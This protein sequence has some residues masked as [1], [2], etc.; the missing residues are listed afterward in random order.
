MNPFDM[1]AQQQIF[2]L[3][4]SQYADIARDTHK[5]YIEVC[6]ALA[7]EQAKV[8]KLEQEL[9]RVRGVVVQSV[10]KEI[11]TVSQYRVWVMNTPAQTAAEVNGIKGD[12]IEYYLGGSTSQLGYK[13]VQFRSLIDMQVD[14][15]MLALTPHAVDKPPVRKD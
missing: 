6:D 15:I 11:L 9:A 8:A 14:C 4:L 13:Q 1:N 10:I 12:A 7:A 2:A 5:M 3:Q